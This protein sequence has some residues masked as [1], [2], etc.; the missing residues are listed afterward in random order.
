[1]VDL[2]KYAAKGGCACKIGPHIL[3]DV[4]QHMKM[5]THPAVLTDASGMEDAGVYQIN[6]SQ[7]IVQTVDFFTPPV[8]DPRLFGRVAACNSLSDIYAM[9]GTPISALNIVGFPVPLVKEGVLRDVLEG[10]NEV[11][12]ETGVA[13]LGGHS[14]ENEVPI[15]GMAVTGLIDPHHIWTNGD[16]QVGDVL[17][18]SKPIGTGIMNTAAK[19]GVFPEGVEEAMQSMGTIN[20]GARDV[21]AQFTIHGCTD[22]TGFSLIGHVSEMAKASGTSVELYAEQIPLFTD[23]VEAARMGLV[24]AATYGNRKALGDQAEFADH[25]DP[26]WSDICFDPQTSGGLLF[27]CSES[28][29]KQLLSELQAKGLQAAQIGRVI[30]EGRKQ[31]YVK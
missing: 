29:G 19:G 13:L 8:A 12:L 17:I 3:E 15:F 10:A 25:L 22:I 26:V 6:E 24:P 14:I 5:P 16:A 21:A 4:L 2:T 7:A 20:K 30:Q 18:L 27:A 1:M 9:G 31:V 11:L 28:E 23:V